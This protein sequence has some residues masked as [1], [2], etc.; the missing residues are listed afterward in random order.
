VAKRL[1]I[2]KRLEQARAELERVTTPEYRRSLVGTIGADPIHRRSRGAWDSPETST[3]EARRSSRA[4]A[5]GAAP[6]AP[7]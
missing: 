3:A 2:A 6:A 4:A 7:A 1:G 5:V